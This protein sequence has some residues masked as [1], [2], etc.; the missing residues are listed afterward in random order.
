MG[1]IELVV[2]I[3][4]DITDELEKRV[5]QKVHGLK[6]D[7]MRLIH[8]EKMISLGKLAAGAVHE[9]NNPLSGINS[10]ARLMQQELESG[11]L[12]ERRGRRNSYTILDLSAQN[13][14]AAV[15]L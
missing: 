7:L 2:E 5:E 10:L 11:E 6:K 4:R 15:E 9:I 12:D 13:P 14:P 1:R 8:E 3:F